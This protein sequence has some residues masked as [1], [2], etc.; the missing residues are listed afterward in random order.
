MN[1][2]TLAALI[3]FLV[4]VCSPGANA[5]PSSPFFDDPNTFSQLPEVTQL[6]K[7]FLNSESILAVPIVQVVGA[8]YRFES[9]VAI[10]G[11]TG[12]KMSAPGQVSYSTI[13]LFTPKSAL[14]SRGRHRAAVLIWPDRMKAAFA[15]ARFQ[16][17]D[18]DRYILQA[19]N[20]Y[21]LEPIMVEGSISQLLSSAN[22][23]RLAYEGTEFMHPG[24]VRTAFLKPAASRCDSLF[25]TNS[26]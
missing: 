1:S 21:K 14:A 9:N 17:L 5:S 13:I 6:A 7:T 25:S 26:R 11:M 22:L 2:K 18:G 12:I 10:P 23:A 24:D 4:V 15:E 16:T 3:A 20:T 19:M 8:N